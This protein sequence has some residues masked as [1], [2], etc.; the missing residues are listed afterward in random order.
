MTLR[1]CS[2]AAALAVAFAGAAQAQQT[3]EKRDPAAT[4]RTDAKVERKTTERRARSSEEDRI[5]AQYKAA[6]EKCEALKDNAQ[7]VCEKEAKA[8]EKIAKA[9][10]AAKNNPS[11][12]NQRRVA[13]AKADGEYDVAKEKC[14]DMKGEQKDA[15]EKD[16]KAKRDQAKAQ[17]SKQYAQRKDADRPATS[18]STTGGSTK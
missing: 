4:P 18:G 2:I 15:C 1:L 17:I 12:R 13:E 16:A 8:Q 10:L 6:K 14:D 3:P 7:D 11:Q 9:E 5:E